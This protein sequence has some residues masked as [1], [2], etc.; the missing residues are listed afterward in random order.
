VLINNPDR[1][2]GNL[3]L[4]PDP[5]ESAIKLWAI[6]A[7]NALIGWPSDYAAARDDLP[8]LRNLAR[9]LPVSE[10]RESALEAAEMASTISTLEIVDMVVHACHLAHE[11][12]GEL[13]TTT[14]VSRCARA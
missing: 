6:D 11:P 10:V 14:L 7:G 5:D 3:L 8:S 2:A 13:I 4:Q 12:Q 9:G 1:H